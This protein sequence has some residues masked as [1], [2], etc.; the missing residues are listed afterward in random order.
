VAVFTPPGSG[1]AG[2]AA[3]IERASPSL[4][5][6]G[7][8]SLT[9]SA[10]GV[11][12]GSSPSRSWSRVS[13]MGAYSLAFTLAG[14]GAFRDLGFGLGADLCA[15]DWLRQLVTRCTDAVID[16]LVR[17]FAAEDLRDL[18]RRTA[19]FDWR[20]HSGARPAAGDQRAALPRAV[21]LSRG[22]RGG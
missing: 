17:A 12:L 15:G 18:V 9:L 3:Q 22:P 19:R 14:Y 21:P 11:G 7:P 4:L 1:N 16:Q 5:R 20:P 2:A 10:L 13:A 6:S 8:S